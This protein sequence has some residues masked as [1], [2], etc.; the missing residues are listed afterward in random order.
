[1]IP[2]IL[3]VLSPVLICQLFGGLR[4]QKSK[5]RFLICTG[6]VFILFLGL[7]SRYLGSTDTYNYYNMYLRAIN[8]SSWS[9]YYY[10]DGV[11]VGFQAM[12]WALS[13][14]FRFPQF[15]IIFSSMIYVATLFRFIYK[16]SAD[17]VLSII[18]YCTLGLMTFQM[19]G[20][21]Q[22]IAMSMGIIAYEFAKERKLIPFTIIVLLSTLIHQ[23]AIVLLVL[24]PVCAFQFNTRSVLLSM[25]L[26]IALL[27]ASK[28]VIQYANTLF[29]RNYTNAVDSGGF[30]STAIK[31][32]IVVFAMIWDKR[33]KHSPQEASLYFIS[34][35]C[36]LVYVIRYTGTLAAER[37][38]FYFVFAQIG[39]IPNTIAQMKDSDKKL[40]NFVI[41]V[42]CILLMIYHLRGSEF[43]PY[44]VLF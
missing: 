15:I 19:Q 1:M 18:I 44:R 22:S 26:A 35:I 3:L 38:S 41:A 14:I 21:R 33:M 23:T 5:K 9:S 7:R 32:L 20:M 40:A 34:L 25:V 11:E 36:F 27:V 17:P 39:L 8:S 37:I 43:I 10:P 24:Y 12:C 2:Y 31:A 6:I 4:S 13:R 42:L 30:I 29:D 16:N 28:T